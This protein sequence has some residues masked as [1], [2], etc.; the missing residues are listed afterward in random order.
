MV[1]NWF[2]HRINFCPLT[3][4]GKVFEKVDNLYL[5]HDGGYPIIVTDAKLL[6]PAFVECCL[7]MNLDPEN[8]AVAEFLGRAFDLNRLF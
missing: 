3:I 8:I 1:V 6:Y 5:F 2:V 7:D 4:G